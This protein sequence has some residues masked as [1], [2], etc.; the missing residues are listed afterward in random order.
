VIWLVLA[1]VPDPT[2]GDVPRSTGGPGGWQLLI[3]WSCVVVGAVAF[4]MLVAGRR[5]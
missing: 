5:H 2:V 4:A 1:V 3:A